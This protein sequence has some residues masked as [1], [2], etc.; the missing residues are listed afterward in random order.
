MA[1]KNRHRFYRIDV[2][3]EKIL[4]ERSAEH[5][6]IALHTAI[7]LADRDYPKNAV[8]RQIS[9]L[10]PDHRSEHSRRSDNMRGAETQIVLD[11]R[12]EFR[13]YQNRT[14][15]TVRILPLDMDDIQNPRIRIEIVDLHQTQLLGTESSTDEECDHGIRTDQSEII[16][17][18]IGIHAADEYDTVGLRDGSVTRIRPVRT[19]KRISTHALTDRGIPDIIE[20][21][22]QRVDFMRIFLVGIAQ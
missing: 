2:A 3:V 14:G 6:C 13:G 22:S 11:D 10:V 19:D 1:H 15:P 5:P 17:F 20:E 4:S 21:D 8:R 9:C 18:R 7:L 16:R 12:M